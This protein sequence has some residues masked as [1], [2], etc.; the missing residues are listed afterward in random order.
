MIDSVAVADS[1]GGSVCQKRQR[2]DGEIE[3]HDDGLKKS[4]I[5]EN[6]SESKCF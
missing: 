3:S 1:S 5:Y 6:R 4:R 2:D